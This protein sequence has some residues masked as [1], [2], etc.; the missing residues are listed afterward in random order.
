MN[1]TPAQWRQRRTSITSLMSHFFA[2][3]ALAKWGTR[4]A[5]HEE[6][7]AL[8]Q[9]AIDNTGYAPR[10]IAPK[11]APK[12]PLGRANIHAA[13][14]E[15]VY[16]LLQDARA[17][18]DAIIRIGDIASAIGVHRRTVTSILIELCTAGRISKRRLAGGRGLFVAFTPERDVIIPATQE[19]ELPAPA[20]ANDVAPTIVE[21]TR[22]KH[23]VF[24]QD[25]AEADH[26]S[27]A[28]N[29]GELPADGYS[30]DCVRYADD[31]IVWRLWDDACDQVLSEHATE[32]AALAPEAPR[33]ASEYQSAGWPAGECFW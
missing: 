24:L 10:P 5:W 17:G 14:V 6:M 28:A 16:S 13:T 21:E 18:T 4:Q 27:Q 29:S 1:R 30:I 25:R 33:G 19:A 9:Y 22:D 31:R 32:G 2:A 8:W 26:I 12:R 7:A 23:P 11:R 3:Q 15:Q 20:R